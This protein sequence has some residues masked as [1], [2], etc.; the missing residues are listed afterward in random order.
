[1]TKAIKKVA[2]FIVAIA[3]LLGTLALV[4]GCNNDDPN[5]ALQ[6]ELSALQEEL[7]ALQNGSSGE[8]DLQAIIDDL[9]K[10]VAALE[11]SNADLQKQI[12]A[13]REE[14]EKMKKQEDFVLTISVDKATVTHG[15]KITANAVLK[16]NTG[17]SHDIT[18]VY[19]LI[20]WVHMD[21]WLYWIDK[22]APAEPRSEVFEKD[23][24]FTSSE[25]YWVEQGQELGTYEL[26]ATATFYLNFGQPNQ[27]KIVVNSNKIN[28]TVQ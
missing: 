5:L 10:R 1:M 14:L 2:I 4:T 28:I 22:T 18:V 21:G 6:Q 12:D 3:M 25:I 16:N 27:E 13:L 24:T 7:Y 23:G 15:Q 17:Q 8:V 19:F 11:T 9:L 26:R 20:N